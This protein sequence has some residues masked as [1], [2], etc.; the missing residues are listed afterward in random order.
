MDIPIAWVLGL[1]RLYVM[2]NESQD[3]SCYFGP[4]GQL[5]AHM[6]NAKHREVTITIYLQ[7]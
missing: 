4:L 1:F 7:I 6:I 3:S 5:A 2:L